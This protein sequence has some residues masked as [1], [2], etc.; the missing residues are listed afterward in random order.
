MLV[1]DGGV[2]AGQ[3]M[4]EHEDAGVEHEDAGV[5]REDAGVEPVSYSRDIDPIWK[6]H[7]SKCHF[8]GGQIPNLTDTSYS[9][10]V[11]TSDELRTAALCFTQPSGAP[12]HYV[13]PGRP[14]LSAVLSVTGHDSSFMVGCQTSMPRG[15][16]ALRVSNP[17]QWALIRRWIAEGALDN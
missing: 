13:E 5:E 9:A 17:L 16:P 8:Y 12:A 15:L 4:V 14:E 3:P 11:G 7:C 1:I 10:L 6:Q 2:D